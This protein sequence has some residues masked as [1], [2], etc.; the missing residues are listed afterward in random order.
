MT[1]WREVV[2]AHYAWAHKDDEYELVMQPGASD[3]TILT[4]AEQTGIP[5]TDEFREFYSQINGFGVTADG[6]KISWL[7]V[8]I[9]RI[10]ATIANARDWFEET[11][12][13]LASRYFPFIDWDS[14]D[15]TGYLVS[16]RGSLLPD[17]YDFD[18]E[19]YE[20]D[21]DQSSAEILTKGDASVLEFLN[22]R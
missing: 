6:E 1:N 2:Q 14:G 12:P 16:E 9:E 8:P 17:L 21:E 10:A 20:F 4:M 22:G 18:H 11:H 3:A 13:D 5:L 15:Y 19:D 7:I